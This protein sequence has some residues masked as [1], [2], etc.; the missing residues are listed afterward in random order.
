MK[1]KIIVAWSEKLTAKEIEDRLFWAVF[2]AE[3]KFGKERIKA[4]MDFVFDRQTL[5]ITF[6]SANEI[7]TFVSNRVLGRQGNGLEIG[8]DSSAFSAADFRP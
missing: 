4:E 3:E 5:E 1:S 2:D 7:N 6:P 8:E